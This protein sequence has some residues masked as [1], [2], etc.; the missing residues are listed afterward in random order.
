MKKTYHIVVFGCQMNKN[1]SERMAT[2][3]ENLGFSE[4]SVRDKADLVLFTTCGV[5]GS[6]ESRIYGII[7]KLKKI[8]PNNVIVLTGCLSQRADVQKI[9]KKSVDIWMNI[10]DLPKL[11]ELLPERLRAV[12]AEEIFK[13]HGIRKESYFSIEAKRQ[14][15]FAAYVPI[16]NGCDNFCTYCVVPYA[17]GREVYRPAGEI[18][19][20]VKDLI[21]KGYKEINLIAQ[22]VN[23]YNSLAPRERVGVRGDVVN[24]PELLKMVNDIPGEFWLRFSTNHP[25]DMSEELIEMVAQC[26]KVCR[27]IHV[28]AQSGSNEILQRMNRKYTRE[29][30]LDLIKKIRAGLDADLPVAITTDI[31]V[32]FPGETE[33]HFLDTMR[34]F[35]EVEFDMAYVSEYS[36]RPGTAAEKM[37][38]DVTNE[39]KKERA[40]RLESIL[41]KIIKKRNEQY[42]GKTVEML[43]EGINKRGEWYG[44]TRA[45]KVIKMNKRIKAEAGDFVMV[46]IVKIRNFG[47]EADEV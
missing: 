2:Y 8:N 34:L 39:V 24:F 18:V 11:H 5:R 46:K 1:D 19:A 31:I 36:S 28:P 17:R 44:K 43:V 6:A 47:F 23:S 22:N 16:G 10:I 20:E 21:A 45:G 25:K 40:Q 35:E 3:L 26:E 14:S 27:H 41:E 32:G 9:L 29:H 13:V 12:N 7:P 33:E 37:G 30:Y 38:D 4:E 15:T 42:L